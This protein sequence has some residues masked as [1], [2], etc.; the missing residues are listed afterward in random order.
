MIVRPMRLV[1]GAA[2]FSLLGCHLPK[3]PPEPVA[4]ETIIRDLPTVPREVSKVSV[5][6]SLYIDSPTSMQGFASFSGAYFEFFQEVE[7]AF[8]RAWTRSSIN[9]YQFGLSV[10]Q[11][12]T[13]PCYSAATKSWILQ[14]P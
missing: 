8:T 14:S 9:C 13:Q 10:A 12:H 3:T 2:V 11:L 1:T 6:A 7:R 5:S 4:L